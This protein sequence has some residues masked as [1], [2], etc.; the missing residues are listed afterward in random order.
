MSGAAFGRNGQP[1]GIVREADIAQLGVRVA[2]MQRIKMLDY[3]PSRLVRVCVYLKHVKVLSEDVSC[4]EQ[5]TCSRD[6]MIEFFKS[7]YD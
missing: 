1:S 4:A 5:T 3:R 7:D 2:T 6:V